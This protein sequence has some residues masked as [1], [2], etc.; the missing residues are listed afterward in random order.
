MFGHT[1][2]DHDRRYEQGGE[3]YDVMMRIFSA[4]EPFDHHGEFYKMTGVIAK[5][6]Q[7][8]LTMSAATSARRNSSGG[9]GADIQRARD[10]AAAPGRTAPVVR[11]AEPHCRH[12]RLLYIL[13]TGLV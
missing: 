3:W 11:C 1:L 2:A 8:P 6:L 10:A 9:H 4:R 12:P 7:L 13:S 5:P